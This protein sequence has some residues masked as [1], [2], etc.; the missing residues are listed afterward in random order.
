MSSTATHSPCLCLLGSTDGGVEA[1]RCSFGGQRNEGENE[2]W[3]EMNNWW[4]ILFFLACLFCFCLGVFFFPTGLTWP[5]S[6]APSHS[7]D[8]LRWSLCTRKQLT[9]QSSVWLAYLSEGKRIR[10]A[11][12]VCAWVCLCLLV[13]VCV[14]SRCTQAHLPRA[15]APVHKVSKIEKRKEGKA[16]LW[17]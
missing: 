15:P 6:L 1:S 13:C 5:S 3:Q 2:V 4:W 16:P 10:V 12:Y 11:A 8:V 7:R 17:L 9:V 14:G